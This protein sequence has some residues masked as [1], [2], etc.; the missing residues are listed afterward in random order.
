MDGPSESASSES[1]SN[2]APADR[3]VP[4]LV[5]RLATVLFVILGLSVFVGLCLLLPIQFDLSFP[6]GALVARA[7]DVAEGR[8]PYSD[9]REWPHGFAPYA[10]L[11]Y[12]P[13]GWIAR[14]ILDQPETIDYY[15]LGRAHSFVFLIGLW[16]LLVGM[17]RRLALPWA[18]AVMPLGLFLIWRWL[19][20]FAF[21]F[22]PDA[23]QVFF[24]MLG[25]WIALGGRAGP[26]RLLLVLGALM[27]SFWYKPTS[28]GIA[29]ALALWTWWGMG[30]VKAGVAWIGFGAT[31]LAAALG[32]NA[33]LDGALISNMLGVTDVGW[34]PLRLLLRWRDF[35]PLPSAI[36]ILAV[37]VAVVMLGRS[38]ESSNEADST[39]RRERLL[40]LAF[41][42][43]LG[44]ALIQYGKNG[45]DRNYFLE[46]Y[47]LGCVIVTRGL[48]VWLNRAG[49]RT[50]KTALA[51]VLLLGLLVVT[52]DALRELKYEVDRSRRLSNELPGLGAYQ[53]EDQLVLA[54]HPYLALV[55]GSEPSVLDAFQFMRLTAD[56][57][58]LEAALLKRVREEAFDLIVIPRNATY[59][60]SEDFFPL[61]QRHYAEYGLLGPNVVYAPNRRFE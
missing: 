9:W 1:V 41:V 7:R 55:L 17:G 31:G 43:S 49:Q 42:C 13:P 37:P 44:F 34:E 24:A 46:S 25:L 61:L 21:S 48:W 54:Y 28:W 33:W 27:A 60:Y 50:E 52:G 53:A 47:A 8:T 16:G 18:A 11:T 57:P 3:G 40:A 32:V 39:A 14:A 45:A 6:E 58:E 2:P 12:Y 36:L 5:W 26:G 29:L 59:L 15:R 23:P 19:Q 56:N 35:P 22:R 4:P 20:E 51:A 30:A 38:R 10:P